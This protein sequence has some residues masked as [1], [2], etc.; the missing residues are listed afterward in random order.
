MS[1]NNVKEEE[2]LSK[3]DKRENL[4]EEALQE[5]PQRTS[6]D[7]LEVEDAGK[8]DPV[9]RFTRIV[10][11]VLAALFIWYVL[12]DRYAPHTDQAR[13]EGFVVPIAPKVSGMVTKV[14]VG[15]GIK[16]IVQA[17]EVLMEIDP[18]DYKIA[19]QTAKAE[20]DKTGQTIGVETASIKSA[21]AMLGD[22]RAQLNRARQDYERLQRI[23]KLDP[24]AVSKAQLDKVASALAEAKSQ[25]AGAEAEVEKARQQLGKKGRYNAKIRAA[26]AALEQ[27]QIN[28][29]ET[30]IRAPSFGAIEN[31][32]ID[33]GHRAKAGVPVMT[34]VS[35]RDVWVKA[36]MRENSIGNLK[37]G[38]PAEIVLDVR[39]G[40]V[41]S[42][43]VVGIS[44]GVNYGK[45]DK[46]GS[47]AAAEG[48]SGWLRDAQR[49]PV[50]IRLT[51]ER[52]SGYRR[53]GG[54]ADVQ[55]Y[56]GG[57]WL[58]HGLGWLWIRLMSILSYV[59]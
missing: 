11:W 32:K 56:P 25:L 3:P 47:L 57:N 22:E 55:I 39:P 35:A 28:L 2:T 44:W 48:K 26:A 16:Q 8:P 17:G 6:E 20:L 13:V 19:V 31:L 46:P 10:L 40:R 41:F 9:R 53:I 54:Q 27:A 42:G 49:I 33:V 7:S 1:Q 37:V 43:K 24:G 29:A 23:T 51:D 50:Y 4:Q 59:Y 52:S 45:D 58:L 21:A 5:Q 38:D 12:A 18:R 14:H 36:N 15:I 34:F 30:V